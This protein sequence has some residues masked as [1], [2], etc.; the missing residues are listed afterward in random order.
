MKTPS[1]ILILVIL[2]IIL[3]TNRVNAQKDS[4]VNK[5]SIAAYIGIGV[6]DAN[7]K[8]GHPFQRGDAK[9]VGL[10]VGI[11]IKGV[12]DLRE[13]LGMQVDLN[14]V[15]RG[16][17]YTHKK[18]P[19]DPAKPNYVLHRRTST[20]FRIMVGLNYYFVNTTKKQ[21]YITSGFGIKYVSR[22][23]TVDENQADL[24]YEFPYLTINHAN[25][26]INP[27]LRFGIGFRRQIS[28]ILFFS[29]EASIGSNPI[30]FGLGARL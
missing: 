28:A 19:V 23:Y 17:T 30:Q 24:F 11:G 2:S 13:K 10:P 14:F 9:L 27:A 22:N 16:V 29:G 20:K 8:I 5:S 12:Y 1:T 26:F 4:T 6:M 3:I 15:H 7:I 21:L 18:V 25:K